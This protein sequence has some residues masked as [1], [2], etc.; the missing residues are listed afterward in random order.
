M[1]TKTSY[2][3]ALAT[4]AD[5]IYVGANLRAA[6]IDE[7][8]ATFGPGRKQV[9]TTV[10]AW[11]VS[12]DTTF[13]GL[14]DEEPICLF[15][16]GTPSLLSD[17]GCPWM[18]GTDKVGFY[19][20]AFLRHSRRVV[21]LWSEQFPILRNYVDARNTDAVRWLQWVGFDVYYPRPWGPLNMNF[22]EFEMRV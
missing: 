20:R 15:G 10:Q 21:A 4:K 3:I 1:K 7:L 13:V 9:A 5:A 18:L 6:D 14:A 19:S 16:L 22:H 8:E 2:N 11:R 17:V 12:R